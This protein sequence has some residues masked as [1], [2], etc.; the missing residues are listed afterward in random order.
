MRLA[1]VLTLLFMGL[2]AL[3]LR[4]APAAAPSSRSRARW[5]ELEVPPRTQPP[6]SM[7]EKGEQI[8]GWNCLPCHGPDGRGDGPAILRLGRRA[9]DFTRGFF[10]LKTSGPGEL[11]HDDDL[12]R[13]I[14]GGVA[15]GGMPASAQFTSE[16]LWSLVDHVKGLSQRTLDDGA[17]LRFFDARPPKSRIA[18][19][20]D[21]APDA[22]RGAQLYRSAQCG[23][24][25]GGRGRGDGPAAAGLVDE[26]GARVPLPD[27]T[28]GEAAF[29]SGERLEDVFRVLTT[30]MAGTPMPAFDSIAA[31]DRRDLAAYVV[32]LYR[33]IPPGEKVF[34]LTGCLTCH[35]LGQGRLIGPDLAGTVGRY[36]RGWLRR[37]LKDPAEMMA[38]DE[39][40]KALAKEYPVRMPAYGLSDL[41]IEQVLDYLAANERR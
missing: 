36:G 28:R 19:P 39:K 35:T 30:G 23:T 9:R 18:A 16:E 24:C 3:T 13:T 33:P 20:P 10:K 26:L 38:T 27:L 40:A 4:P 14:L 32:S 11:P 29:K 31:A 21:G 6:G 15:A 8:F 7:E 17:V 41:E 5:A 2:L 37:W 22:R 25:H 12:Y 34:L 1:T